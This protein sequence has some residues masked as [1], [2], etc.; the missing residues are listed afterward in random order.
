MF[1][2]K[3][4]VCFGAVQESSGDCQA[5]LPAKA[6]AG[7]CELGRAVPSPHTVQTFHRAFA[8]LGSELA[9]GPAWSRG[10]SQPSSSYPTASVSI[11]K[12]CSFQATTTFDSYSA[13]NK[14]ANADANIN[15]H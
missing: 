14:A 10:A 15:S 2:Q 8:Q 9:T 4:S 3:L 7:P 13:V 5:A 6:F 12:P 11:N 1:F